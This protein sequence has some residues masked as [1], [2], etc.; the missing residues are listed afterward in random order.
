MQLNSSETAAQTK[1]SAFSTST[2]STQTEETAIT[3]HTMSCITH[4]SGKC[5]AI[6]IAGISLHF[7][8]NS[9][10]A[11]H[12]AVVFG[13]ISNLESMECEGNDDNKFLLLIEKYKGAFKDLSSTNSHY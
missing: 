1:L 4:Q 9:D 13:L 7:C 2:A 8:Y 12:E 6:T 5:I 3:C 11:A 10:Q